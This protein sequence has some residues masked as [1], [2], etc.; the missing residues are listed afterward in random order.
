M[1]K[2]DGYNDVLCSYRRSQSRRAGLISAKAVFKPSFATDQT[3]I[4]TSTSIFQI[5]VGR[6]SGS[7]AEGISSHDV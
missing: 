1:M 4:M 5:A 7:R 3:S 6:N 2:S